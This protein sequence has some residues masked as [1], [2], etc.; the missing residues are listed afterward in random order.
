MEETAKT[1]R[2][3]AKVNGLNKVVDF[4]DYLNPGGQEAYAML[5]GIGGAKFARSSAIRVTV[6]DYSRGTGEGKSVSVYAS[7]APETIEYLFAVAQEARVLATTERSDIIC[8]SETSADV[9]KEAKKQLSA[10]YK[11]ISG[12]KEAG[13]TVDLQQ[14]LQQIEVAGK[15]V[16]AA[17]SGVKKEAFAGP[18]VNYSQDRVHA[19]KEKNGIA[20]VQKL[21][22]SRKGIR[23]NGSVARYPWII[24]IM[25]GEASLIRKPNGACTFDAKSL[26]N[27]TEACINISDADMFRA[28][29]KCVHFISI[30]ETAICLPQVAQGVHAV[31]Y[32]IIGLN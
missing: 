4:R 21:L 24:Q 29:S 18:T 28:M 19:Y 6:C 25:N 16:A 27:K 8:I 14:L 10:L 3:I 5:H 32:V 15:G 17:M 30:W 7:I 31:G 22:I 23:S 12:A 9:L 1:T 11:T 26:T 2:I 20:P 13:K